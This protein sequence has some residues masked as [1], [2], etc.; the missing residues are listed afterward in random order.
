MSY[1]TQDLHASNAASS[2]S[3][4]ASC[5]NFSRTAAPFFFPAWD[6]GSGTDSVLSWSGCLSDI[7]GS[8]SSAIIHAISTSPY[9]WSI[10]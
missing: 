2:V 8:S 3:G 1:P 9:T 5:P 4:S 6:Y 7:C 10:S